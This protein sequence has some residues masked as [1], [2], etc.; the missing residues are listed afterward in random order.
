MIHFVNNS[1]EMV[2]ISMFQISKVPTREDLCKSAAK[3]G[4]WS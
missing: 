3:V 2:R 1:I 4:F